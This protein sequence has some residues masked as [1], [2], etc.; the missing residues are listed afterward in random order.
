[1]NILKTF[2]SAKKIAIFLLAFIFAV[3]LVACGEQS[4]TPYG[5]ISA[6]KTYL[7]IGD[8]EVS[9]KRLYDQLRTSSVARLNSYIEELVSD[10]DI[11]A[12]GEDFKIEAYEQELSTA[13]F[14]SSITPSTI[15]SMSS[16]TIA[17]SILSYA[18]S[19]AITNLSQPTLL[20][21]FLEKV[22]DDVIA[23][24]NA[25]DFDEKMISDMDSLIKHIQL[26]HQSL[27]HRK[28]I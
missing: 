11:N 13:L 14:S 2:L 15:G 7:K 5:S 19:F 22:I 26:I 8:Y 17:Q 24:V 6:E 28:T 27:K 23:R 10:V 12:A 1:M 25:V 16:R 18:D 21:E 20:V 4:G 9:Q 3:T